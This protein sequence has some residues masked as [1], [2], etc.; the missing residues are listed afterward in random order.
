[1]VGSMY[2]IGICLKPTTNASLAMASLSFRGKKDFRGR[3]PATGMLA[4]VI[5]GTNYITALIAN[6][7][8]LRDRFASDWTHLG[9]HVLVNETQILLL[10]SKGASGLRGTLRMFVRSAALGRSTALEVGTICFRRFD[11]DT[12]HVRQQVDSLIR[13]ACYRI[14]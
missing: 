2:F 9:V 13:S 1:M 8:S 14:V 11:F 3:P 6:V 7:E 5:N 4:P 12:G 10:R